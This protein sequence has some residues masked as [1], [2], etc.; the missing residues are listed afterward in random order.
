LRAANDAH[1]AACDGACQANG[2]QDERFAGNFEQ[3]FVTA[4][5]GTFSAGEDEC[6]EACARGGR[7]VHFTG[8]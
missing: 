5:A 4:H 8:L 7:D 1:I 3:S 6:G 2:A